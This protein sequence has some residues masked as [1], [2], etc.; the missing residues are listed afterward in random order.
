[1]ESQ[2]TTSEHAQSNSSAALLDLATLEIQLSS[3]I[4]TRDVGGRERESEREEVDR[5]TERERRG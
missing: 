2:N 5:Q 4:L 3:N 1:V